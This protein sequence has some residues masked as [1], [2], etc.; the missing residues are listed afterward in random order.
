MCARRSV[1]HAPMQ[2]LNRTGLNDRTEYTVQAYWYPLTIPFD[3]VPKGPLGKAEVTAQWP[4][5]RTATRPVVSAWRP[6]ASFSIAGSHPHQARRGLFFFTR[7]GVPRPWDDFGN[8][9][10][11][12]P[13]SGSPGPIW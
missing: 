2:R 4:P 5:H 11:P 9:R 1:F 12:R 3:K 6:G 10:Y 13:G 7:L 8:R